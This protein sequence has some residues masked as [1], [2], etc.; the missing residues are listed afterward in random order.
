MGIFQHLLHLNYNVV[1]L[2][3][4]YSMIPSSLLKVGANHLF[5]NSQLFRSIM[6]ESAILEIDGVMR[7][8]ELWRVHNRSGGMVIVAEGS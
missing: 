6:V 7:M 2:L 1:E 4:G 3:I 5:V 8:C